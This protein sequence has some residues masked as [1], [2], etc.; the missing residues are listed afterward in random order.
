MTVEVRL[1]RFEECGGRRGGPCM[2]WADRLGIPGCSGRRTYERAVKPFGSTVKKEVR[3]EV[4]SRE[5]I[6]GYVGGVGE[7][8]NDGQKPQGPRE[9]AQKNLESI[10]LKIL[11]KRM[12][13]KYLRGE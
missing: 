12:F 8:E 7:F 11:K 5:K 6:W 10:C 3:M 13:W 2:G 9:R 4:E 1:H